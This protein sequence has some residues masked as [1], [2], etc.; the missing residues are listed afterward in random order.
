MLCRAWKRQEAIRRPIET[1][2]LYHKYKIKS[3][4]VCPIFWVFF[5]PSMPLLPPC[6][7]WN[8][9]CFIKN[10]WYNNWQ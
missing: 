10:I 1:T 7:L 3:G 5:S 6:S 4:E 9:P 2:E 8:L